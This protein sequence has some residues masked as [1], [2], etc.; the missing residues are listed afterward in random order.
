MRDVYVSI[1]KNIL[2][3]DSFSVYSFSSELSLRAAG[4]GFPLATMS[5]APGYL[6]ENRRKIE[7]KEISSSLIP[8]LLVVFTQQLEILVTTM[9]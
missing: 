5:V 3:V 1:F 2:R 4:R 7:P 6:L 8:H 9:I